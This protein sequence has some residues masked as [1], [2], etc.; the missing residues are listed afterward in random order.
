MTA[1]TGSSHNS[2]SGLL[3]RLR[4][5]ATP[6]Q[7]VV[8]ANDGV[9]ATAGLLEGF[10]GAGTDDRT[11]ILAASAMI[12]A[13]SLGLAGAKWA[14]ESGELDAE[15]LII[16]AERSEL[17]TDPESEVDELAAYWED[18][19]L[20]PEIARGV[21]EQLSAQD[22]LA[23]QLA[24]EHNIDEPTP[25]WQPVWAGM[26]ACIAFFLGSMIPLIIT[27]FVPVRYEGWVILFA[28]LVS[29]T[30]TS[31]LGASAG[32]VPFVRTLIRTLAVGLGA[33]GISYFLGQ[34]L[35]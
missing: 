12:A 21:A 3:E 18:R 9:I 19:G 28:V 22:A 29:L 16:E 14:E 11:L 27:M 20:S 1:G 5:F 32:R 30:L 6:R 13:G 8:D 33:M 2:H 10:V 31:L 23:A 15:R 34:L 24:F 25:A 7:W 4:H 26:T 17:E 35:H